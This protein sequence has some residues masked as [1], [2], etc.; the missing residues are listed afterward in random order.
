MR[1]VGDSR[2]RQIAEAAQV[3]L[4]EAEQRLEEAKTEFKSS[5]RRLY[6]EGATIR[7]ISQVLGLSHQRIH[8]LIGSQSRSWWQRLTGS[9]AQSTESCSFCGKVSAEVGQLVSGPGVNICEGC[10]EAAAVTLGSE[11][12]RREDSHFELL[13]QGSKQRCSFCGTRN[14]DVPRASASG[15]QICAQCVALATRIAD[16]KPKT[17]VA[18]TE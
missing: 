3:K 10:V 4:R 6:V 17:P 11:A 2:H 9:N 14:Q 7:E 1:D 8:Q 12:A 18:V 13:H 15:H 5:V 16:E